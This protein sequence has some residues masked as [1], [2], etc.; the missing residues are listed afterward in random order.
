MFDCTIAA[1]GRRDFTLR[2]LGNLRHVALLAAVVLSFPLATWAQPPANSKQLQADSEPARQQFATAAA[3]QNR[4]QF[5][6]AADEWAK[7]LR[8]FGKDSLAPRARHY[9]GLC[10]LKAKQY[11]AVTKTLEPLLKESAKFDL[12]EPTFL[13]LGLAQYNVGQ[14]GDKAEYAKAIATFEQL[15][16]KFPQGSFAA[17]ALFYQG[18]SAYGQGDKAQAIAAYR[19]LVERFP[20]DP[21]AAD[22]LYALGVTSEELSKPKDAGAAYSTFLTSFPQHALATEVGM[23]LGES[24]F[25]EGKIA[26]AEGRFATAAATAD[27][28]LADHAAMRQAACLYQ[29]NEYTA[30]AKLYASIPEKF[31]KTKYASTA[32]LAAGKCAYLAGDYAQS[33][34]LLAALQKESGDVG[35]EAGHWAVRSLLKQQ[36]PAEALKLAESLAK[37]YSKGTWAGQLALD[38]ADALFENKRGGDAIAAYASIVDQFKDDPIAPQALYLAAFSALNTNDHAAALKHAEA[39][40]KR[41]KEHELG[42]DVSYIAA[43]STLQR[44]EYSVAEKLYDA[45]ISQ[46]PNHRDIGMWQLRRALCLFL[47]KQYPKVI[48]SLEPVVASLPTAALKAEGYYLLGASQLE[49]QKFNEAVTSLQNALKADAQWRQADET[50]LALAQALRE[51]KKVD[52]AQKQLEQ[53][54][55][56]FPQSAAR[57]R[58]LYRLAD[59]AFAKQDYQRA[60]DDY[61]KLLAEHAGSKLVPHALYGLGWSLFRSGDAAGAVKPLNDLL[62]EHAKSEVASQARYLR[63]LV[64]QD[65]KEPDKAIADL[66]AYLKTKPKGVELSNARYALGLAQAAA[67]KPDAAVATFKQLLA[68]DAKYTDR[69]KVLYELAWALKSDNKSDEAADTFARLAKEHA[70]SGLAAES[71]YHVGDRRYEQKQWKDAAMA[72]YDAVSKAGETPLAEKATHKLGWVYYQQEKY[73]DAEKTFTYQEETWP[74]GELAADAKFMAAESLFKQK[75]YA[76]SLAAYGKLGALPRKELTSIA[77]LHAAQSASALENWKAAETFATQAQAADG[78]SPQLAEMIYEQAWAAQNQG[79]ADDALKLYEDVT[80]KSTTEAAARARF[81]IG[82]ICFERKE[83]KDAIR[84]FFKV[85]YVYNYPEWQAAAHYESARCF[86]VLGDTAQA[87]KSYQEVVTQFPMSDR[88]EPARKRLAALGG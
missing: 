60:A 24:L 20:K 39:F 78:T 80:V 64:Q 86:E 52:E 44:G 50:H 40:L 5:E 3:L 63:A 72:Y 11:A 28:A 21:F 61:R 73:D 37:K 1:S 48:Q 16:E 9:L 18:E 75:K 8:D 83:H 4:E 84:H 31:S 35:A 88:V 12:L 87:K 27:F 13:Y 49:E 38:R 41:H 69:D 55:K 34:N 58:A 71:L 32:K 54:L 59:L 65:L 29:R 70:T 57:D 74:K 77:L 42:V 62:K 10:Q 15:L 26:E 43:E 79:R 36:Q 76:E 68:D 7:F 14:T 19:K 53:L 81:M 51:T 66:D 85:A 47:Q 22:A 67:K 33:Q 45:L 23:R 6:L 25:A 17:Q 82:E 56:D 2:R 46:V 30:A